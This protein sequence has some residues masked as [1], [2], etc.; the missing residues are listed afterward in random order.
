MILGLGTAKQKLIVFGAILAIIASAAWIY[1]TQF[2]APAYNVPLHQA[3]GQVLAEETYR[4]LGHSGNVVI[5]SMETRQAPELKTQMEAYEKQLSLLGGITVK[6]R[7]I[8]NP[9]DNPK[10]RP[11]SGLSAKHFLKIV[12]KHAGVGAIVSFVGAP[13]L[14]DEELEQ[15]K[16]APKFIA[17]AHSPE[18]FVNLLDKKILQ[19]AVV[20]R[21]EFPA[22]GPKKPATGRQ[23]FDHYFQII[24]PESL[25]PRQD[26]AP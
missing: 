18:K 19:A 10:Y 9:G 22:P 17:E 7:L 2:R 15:M 8:L 14:S 23:W 5:V 4:A 26:A 16:S 11:G 6:D 24:R 25:P 21:Y 12:R 20:P 1:R 13:Q 3:V